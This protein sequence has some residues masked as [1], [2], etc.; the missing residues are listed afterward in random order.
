[1]SENP[2]AAVRRGRKTAGKLGPALQ[3]MVPAV[4]GLSRTVFKEKFEGQDHIP[5][6]GPALVVLNHISV[7]DPLATASFVWTAGRLPLFLIKDSVF[8]VPLVGKLFTKSR[9]ISVSRGSSAAQA[10]LDAAIAALRDG[11]VVAVYPEGTVTRDPD[12][13]PM[14][15]KTGV[16]RIAL[17]VPEA[18]VI[19]VAQW[20]AHRSFDYHTKKLRLFPRK[21]THIRALPPMDI[22]KYHGRTDNQ[23]ARRLT[24]EMMR[25][26]ADEVGRMRGKPAPAELY[27]F[28]TPKRAGRPGDEKG[29]R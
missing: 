26:L 8:N 6:T 9:Q 17:A 22:S 24:D 1:M 18:P 3:F 2:D 21:Q 19:P 16:A 11:Q 28:V 29:A 14:Q 10:S 20:G 4:R 12:F 5:V 7:L 23:A 27:R 15:A 13:W 25:A